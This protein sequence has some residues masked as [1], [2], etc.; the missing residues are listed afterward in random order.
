MYVLNEMGNG[1]SMYA[2]NRPLFM[3]D[4]QLKTQP[5]RSCIIA[6]VSDVYCCAP[7]TYIQQ[8]TSG[9]IFR[10]EWNL[11][12]FLLVRWRRIY[13]ERG[14]GKKG[15]T[16]INVTKNIKYTNIQQY[17][18]LYT[19]LLYMHIYGGRIIRI[20]QYIICIS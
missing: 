13:L 6:A 11:V 18:E 14:E 15:R 20:Q 12:L 3:R 7:F 16:Q 19:M 4:P 8:Y 10:L 1:R 5:Q 9:N 2:R 17:P